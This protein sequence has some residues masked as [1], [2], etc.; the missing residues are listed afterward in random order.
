MIFVFILILGAYSSSCESVS[1]TLL[2]ELGGYGITQRKYYKA[3]SLQVPHLSKHCL[4]CYSNVYSC[5][6]A[7]CFWSCIRPGSRCEECVKREGCTEK[8]DKCIQ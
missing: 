1:P 5:G 7:K 2:R 3:L 6:Y 4:T 8:F